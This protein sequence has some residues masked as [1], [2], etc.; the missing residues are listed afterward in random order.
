M[1]DGKVPRR[2]EPNEPADGALFKLL[3]AQMVTQLGSGK[4][5]ARYE[6]AAAVALE[7]LGQRLTEEQRAE[8]LVFYRGS[9]ETYRGIEKKRPAGRR[10]QYAALERLQLLA[11]VRRHLFG[12]TLRGWAVARMLQPA[13]QPQEGA[14]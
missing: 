14:A 1:L 8:L 6:G 11:R 3:N 4:V 5:V 12:S 10:E 2:W 7:D 9:D 13:E